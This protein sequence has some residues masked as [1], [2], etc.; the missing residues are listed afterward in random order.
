MSSACEYQN[1]EFKIRT[2]ITEDGEIEKKIC[3]E[4]DGD[5]VVSADCLEGAIKWFDYYEM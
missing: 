5:E 4:V 3:I 1:L 2:R